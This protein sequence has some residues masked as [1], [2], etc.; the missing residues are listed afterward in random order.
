M[1]HKWSLF[2]DTFIT[3]RKQKF[4]HDSLGT[5]KSATAQE[6]FRQVT[7][8]LE[9]HGIKGPDNVCTKYAKNGPNG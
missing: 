1:F 9:A 5:N 2:A 8:P 4:R 3:M 7:I 6:E